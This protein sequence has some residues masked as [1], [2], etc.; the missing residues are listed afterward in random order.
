MMSPVVVA[1]VVLAES[2]ADVDGMVLLSATVASPVTVSSE[3]A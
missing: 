3:P 2:A 1:V